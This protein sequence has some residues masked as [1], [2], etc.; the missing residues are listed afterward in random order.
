MRILSE[1]N[2]GPEPTPSAM[3]R[4]ISEPPITTST[5][6]LRMD[7]GTARAHIIGGA[8]PS[9]ADFQSML[10]Q[11][12]PG[13]NPMHGSPA[14]QQQRIRAKETPPPPSM[15]TLFVKQIR[16]P[17]VVAAIVFFLNLPIITTV[18][19]RYAS[20]MYLGSGEI[21]IG[22]LFVKSL[23]AAGLFA[24]YQVISSLFDQPV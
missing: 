6:D 21:S 10:F 1:M 19:S 4:V 17:L 23:L 11:T 8:A 14:P 2:A 7:P 16:A 20:W 9:L 15:W 12:P 5:G 24:F 22:G 18:M 13:M 3:P